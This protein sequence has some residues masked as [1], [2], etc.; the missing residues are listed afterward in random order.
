MRFTRDATCLYLSLTECCD[1]C[2]RIRAY[3]S[4]GR[5]LWKG[6]NTTCLQPW[7]WEIKENTKSATKTKKAKVLAELQAKVYDLK[8]YRDNVVKLETVSS[9]RFVNV[10][11][12]KRTGTVK[13]SK[14]RKQVLT[15]KKEITNELTPNSEK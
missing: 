1:V 3:E 2:A 8:D 15:P 10:P 7:K 14:K 13:C 11:R 4:L 6:T 12:P 5:K 9:R